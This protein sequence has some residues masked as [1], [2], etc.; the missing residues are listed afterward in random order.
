MNSRFLSK[1]YLHKSF[2]PFNTSD[3]IHIIALN[4]D[5][6]NRF[7]IQTFVSPSNIESNS[8]NWQTPQ[9]K[10]A[11]LYQSIENTA[12]QNTAK[13]LHITRYS[14]RASRDCLTD[15]VG[16]CIFYGLDYGVSI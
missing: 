2:R 16:Y 13:P 5:T 3:A 8:L 9:A 1:M 6:N 4:A 7:V 12:N 15:C 10:Y 11:D 14:H